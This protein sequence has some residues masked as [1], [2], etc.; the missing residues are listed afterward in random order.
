MHQEC[1]AHSERQ[2]FSY[3]FLPPF[4]CFPCW[5]STA[6]FQ[7][8]CAYLKIFEKWGKVCTDKHLH[9]H[10]KD[11]IP[12][13]SP[14]LSL[15]KNAQTEKKT[16]L[17]LKKVLV[18]MPEGEGR[19]YLK[20]EKKNLTQSRSLLI[21]HTWCWFWPTRPSLDPESSTSELHPSPKAGLILCCLHTAFI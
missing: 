18:L 13:V 19:H 7:S 14:A 6:T 8:I 4:F 9:W 20:E 15:N 2:I 21:S 17:L 5:V 3:S 12:L 11:D 1:K 16:Y 10:Q